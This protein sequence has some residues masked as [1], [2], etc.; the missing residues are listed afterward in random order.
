MKIARFAAGLLLALLPVTGQAQE[1]WQTPLGRQ[2]IEEWIGDTT[3]RLNRYRG[4][5]GHEANKPWSINNYGIFIGRNITQNYEPDT[6][7][8]VFGGD[9]HHFMWGALYQSEA[10]TPDWGNADFNAAGVW[11][12]RWYTRKCVEE[13]GGL[14]PGPGPIVP[15]PDGTSVR[16][17]YACY[18]NADYPDIWRAEA[19]CRP[20]GCLFGLMSREQCVALG[21]EKGAR[22]VHHGKPGLG[23]ANECWLLNSCG[24]LR[25][26]GDFINVL[27]PPGPPPPPPPGGYREGGNFACY[28]GA[29][30]PE[31][32]R[33]QARCVGFG[34]QFA[35]MDRDS[36]L[37]LGARMGAA[38]VI[39]GNPWGGRADECWLQN[40]CADM[41]PNGDFTIFRR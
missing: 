36:C 18:G 21:L 14:P 4:S 30:F 12:M 34:C 35:R 7:W 25:P 38:L 13:R 20:F 32:W 28:G 24:D 16:D 40:S 11:G 33:S 2:C 17:G 3:S 8:S 41:R 22:E 19:D 6:W 15:R 26:N 5:R 10:R 39:H 9:K 29:S 37:Q 1:I 31:S 23:R 27:L